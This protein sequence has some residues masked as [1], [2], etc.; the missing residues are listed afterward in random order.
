MLKEKKVKDALIEAG[1]TRL[2]PILM[3]ALTTIFGLVTMAL[4]MGEGAE[5]LQPMAVSTIGGLIYATF[6]TLTIVPTVYAL[7]NHKRMKLEEEEN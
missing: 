5:L 3:T 1:L 7:F 6:L 4:G 2:R